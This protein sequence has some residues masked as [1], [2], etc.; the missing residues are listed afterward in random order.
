MENSQQSPAALD[1]LKVVELPALDPM[2]Y[3]AASMAG[4]TMAE[5]GAEVLKVEPPGTGAAERRF[6][7]F[8]GRQ[9]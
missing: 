3:F 9:S 7:P 5:L 8:A 6:G 1:D 4:K 2:P